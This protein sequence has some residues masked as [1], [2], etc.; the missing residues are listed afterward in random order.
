MFINKVSLT[1]ITLS[2]NINFFVQVSSKE[3]NKMLEAVIFDVDGTLLPTDK[4]QEDW[5]RFYSEKHNKE[6][7][8][9][10][11]REFREFYNFHLGESGSVQGVYDAL[12][13]PCDM[14]DRAH[15]VWEAYEEFKEN[16]Q[17]VPLYEGM[18]ETLETIRAC[19]NLDQNSDMVRRVQLAINTTNTWKGIYSDL[20]AAD[21][22]HLFD[23]KITR[24]TL[25]M[26]QGNGNSDDF[27]KP[28]PVSL[29]LALGI[30]NTP[31]ANTIHVGDSRND[32]IAS[33]K[34][35]RL[36]PLHPETLITVSACY[37]YEGRELLER[38]VETESG[39]VTFDHLIDKPEEL[40]PIVEKYIG[41]K[42]K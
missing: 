21:V 9:K 12:D 22:L 16:Y 42:E 6:W 14:N 10:N 36:N 34:V 31:G 35:I 4:R 25:D 11:S 24:E 7:N 39:I 17:A 15:P 27:Q 1:N 5:F 23:A 8:F 32:L 41:K 2:R 28:S 19:G 37:G 13:L 29:A 26:Y 40:I 20:K 18:K 30:I 3:K 38:G 33:Q